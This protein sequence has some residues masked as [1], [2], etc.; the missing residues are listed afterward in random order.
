[1]N[2]A[3]WAIVA[4]LTLSSLISLVRGFVK[5]AFSLVI[6]ILALVAASVFSSRVE[7]FLEHSISTPSVR[8][9][10]AFGLIFIAV[11][12]LGALLNYCVGLIVKA[13]GLS[14]TDRLI[15]ML[16]GFARGLFIVINLLVYIPAYIPVKS[17]PW[18]QQS[19]L[20]PYFLPYNS[21]VKQAT[22]DVT[23]WVRHLMSMQK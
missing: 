16:F 19:T 7:P 22:N 4:I 21:A 1:M 5:E 12:L 23:Q 14:G 20:I 3:D 8:A 6:W 15:G 2:W 9:M 17:D 13:T 18:F 11:L 10:A